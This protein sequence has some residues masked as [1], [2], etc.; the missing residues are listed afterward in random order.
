MVPRSRGEQKLVYVYF[1]PHLSAIQ[2]FQKRKELARTPVKG[3]VRPARVSVTRARARAPAPA[4]IAIALPPPTRA[5]AQTP[6][7]VRRHQHQHQRNCDRLAPPHRTRARRHR[8]CRRWPLSTSRARACSSA[9]HW[10]RRST[11][12]QGASAP[13]TTATVA[14]STSRRGSACAP[15]RPLRPIARDPHHAGHVHSGWRA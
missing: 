3:K 4:R 6:P 8:P 11:T 7:S 15:I 9:R 12:W 2:L 1:V 14:T 13:S 10:A 5:P